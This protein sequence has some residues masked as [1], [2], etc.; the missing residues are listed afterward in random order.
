MRIRNL[1]ASAAAL[2]FVVPANAAPMS[3]NATMSIFI[4]GLAPLTVGGSG[5]VD[6]TGG[7]LSVP[8][9]LVTTGGSLVVPV[10][11]TS[12][13]DSVSLVG[14]SNLAG[15]FSV[16][17]V[18][19]QAPGEVCPGG[20]SNAGGSGG[21]ACNV[22]G[23]VGGVMGVV[24]TLNVNIIPNVVVIPINLGLALIGQGGSMNTPFL[25]DA[26][27]WTTG[28]AL[29]NTGVSSFATTGSSTAAGFQLVT[30]T[31]MSRA[32]T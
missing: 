6:V 11:A 5:V 24:G 4:Q 7:V 9:G 30:P 3:A 25:I 1:V 32:G 19:S 29:Y 17:G 10:S 12:A 14:F 31:F 27:A 26:A 23:N 2:M 20:V 21:D 13:I 15:V 28:T 18:T 22:G 16:G 8:A